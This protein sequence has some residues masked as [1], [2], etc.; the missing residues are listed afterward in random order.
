MCVVFSGHLQRV[1][2]DGERETEKVVNTSAPGVPLGIQA[3]CYQSGME[4]TH[5]SSAVIF[6]IYIVC[7]TTPPFCGLQ[8]STVVMPPCTT[9]GEAFFSRMQADRLYVV[10]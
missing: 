10:C 8:L 6:L 5:F 9:G 3:P 7:L 4:R 1:P 2:D